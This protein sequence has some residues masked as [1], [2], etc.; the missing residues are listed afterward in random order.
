MHVIPRSLGGTD[1]PDDV[2]PGCRRCHGLYD[3]GQLDLLPFLEPHYRREQ[4]R[5]VEL[6]GLEAAGAG[7]PISVE[8]PMH[9]ARQVAHLFY[10]RGF[11]LTIEE[12]IKWVADDPEIVAEILNLPAGPELLHPDDKAERGG[13]GCVGACCSAG[14]GP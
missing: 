7:S 1:H 10:A 11:A 14:D 9:D 12:A 13:L 8:A 4:A 2:V 5:A 3:T 6:V